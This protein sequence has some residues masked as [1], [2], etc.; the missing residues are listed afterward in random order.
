MNNAI[1]SNKALVRAFYYRLWN[2]WDFA[3]ANMLLSE[4]IV[5][6]GSLGVTKTGHRG[7]ID[8]AEHPARLLSQHECENMVC[9]LKCH[10]AC[11]H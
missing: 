4:D 5:F 10:V 7:F 1:A 6:R 8:Y 3:A 2:Q 11:G 9:P